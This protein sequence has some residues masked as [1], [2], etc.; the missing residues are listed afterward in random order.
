MTIAQTGATDASQAPTSHDRVDVWE[1]V[2]GGIAFAI[3]LAIF[4]TLNP[5]SDLGDPKVLELSS[6]NEAATYSAENT[7]SRISSASINTWAARSGSGT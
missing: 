3:L 4:I 2:R 6:G 1:R 5:F 7:G